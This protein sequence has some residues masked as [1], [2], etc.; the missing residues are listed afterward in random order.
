MAVSCTD[1]PNQAVDATWWWHIT[2]THGDSRCPASVGEHKY[3]HCMEGWE[4]YGS[5]VSQSRD[6]SVHSSSSEDE[7][8]DIGW[9]HPYC[10]CLSPFQW[11][12]AKRSPLLCAR[13]QFLT[14]KVHQNILVVISLFSVLQY[15]AQIIYDIREGS[16][17]F[18]RVITNF[19]GISV[20]A[21]H[22]PERLSLH[23]LL[24]Q[25]LKKTKFTWEGTFGLNKL[26]FYL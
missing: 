26:C 5:S 3:L 15:I 17:K 13:P 18:V 25:F 16:D 12:W 9:T 8:S 14:H 7:S 24:I 20:Q 6:A 1:P 23:I 22:I 10:S 4:V 2:P 19:S 11:A 21:S